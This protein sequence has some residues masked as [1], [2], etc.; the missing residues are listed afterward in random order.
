V[1]TLEDRVNQKAPLDQFNAM[2][3]IAEL[4][5]ENQPQGEE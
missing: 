5:A 1:Y 4:E 3:R 2:E